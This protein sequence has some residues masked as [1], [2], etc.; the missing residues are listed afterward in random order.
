MR[1]HPEKRKYPRYNPV[2][3]DANVTIVATDTESETSYSGTVVDFSYTGIKIKLEEPI[4][5]NITECVIRIELTLP[6][7]GIP[8]SINGKIKHSTDQ[9]EYGFQLISEQVDYTLEDLMFECIKVRA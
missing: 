1:T 8:V 5:S 2:G 3:L 4:A 7:S 6:E 9:D